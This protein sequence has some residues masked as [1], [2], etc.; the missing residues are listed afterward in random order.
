M[1]FRIVSAVRL[2][3][4]V[5]MAAFS[6][7]SLLADSAGPAAE[8]IASMSLPIAM[9]TKERVLGMAGILDTARYKAFIAME[10]LD[11]YDLKEWCGKGKLRPIKEVLDTVAKVA[12]GLNY[13]AAWNAA[14]LLSAERPALNFL[15]LLSA[16]ATLTRRH[17]DAIAGAS[18]GAITGCA[19]T[20]PMASSSAVSTAR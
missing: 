7:P 11:G 14:M 6:S 4:G 10:L 5:L 19:S 16:T 13:I 2:A 15:Q 12:D 17:V 18:T 8:T 3:I 9:M 20:R 1:T